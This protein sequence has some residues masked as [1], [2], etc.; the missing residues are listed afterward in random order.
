MEELLSPTFIWPRHEEMRTI[1]AAREAFLAGK[2][3]GLERLR[4]AIRESWQ[5][6]YRLRVDP[7]LQT[8]PLIL[9]ADELER[10]QE[11]TELISVAAPV[12]ATISTALESERFLLGVSDRQGQLLHLNGHA[13]L[14]QQ[15]RTINAVPGGT[16]A[17]DQ[18]GT[19]IANI[20]LSHGQ[21]DY[22][23]WNEHYCHTFHQWAS[24]GAP[25][26][27]PLT[28]EVIGVAMIG[29]EEPNRFF[30]K[31]MLERLVQRLEQLLH[32]EELR[33]RVALLDA[34][35]RLVLRYPQ[36]IV[37]A[38]DSRGH[39]CGASSLAAQLVHTPH[40]LLDTSLL[41]VPGLYVQ[42]LRPLSQMNNDESYELLVTAAER[43]LIF[44][45]TAIPVPGQRH[46]VGTIIILPYARPPRHSRALT[47]ASS[48]RAR[49]TFAD[50]I[51]KAPAF[52]ECLDLAHQAAQHDFP[53]LLLGESGSG[54]ELLA[55]AIH[56][57]SSRRLGP[58]ITVN[59]GV[60][61]DELLATELFGYIEGAFTD[62]AKG[63]RKG[64]LELAHDGT[65]F[66][67]EVDAMS[68]KMQVSLLRVL[69]ERTVTRVGAERPVAVNIRVI[70]ASNEDLKMATSQKRF[71]LDLYHRLCVVLIRIPSLR[72]RT[73]D[74]PILS[75]HL[76]AQLGFSGLRLSNDA[77]ALLR[78]YHW[79][80]NIRELRNVLLRSAQ[81]ATGTLVTLQDI[82]QEITV[83]ATTPSTVPHGSLHVSEQ[84]LILRVLADTHGNMQ[85]A[86]ARLGIH[87]STLYRK[88][89][90][91]G[92]SPTIG[93]LALAL[94][95]RDR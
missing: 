36:D 50:L 83:A 57:A 44:R 70:A 10:E 75:R 2:A 32:H 38:L 73:N 63:G 52:Q 87:Q 41:R 12:F 49:Y 61:N 1:A 94:N 21:A 60:A 39:I 13:A 42:G 11:G 66:L 3:T 5:R 43:D 82:P 71:R 35:H 78:R 76:L 62:A 28:H 55:Q 24:L 18:V 46:P 15:A 48:W 58:F 23:L 65:L 85:Q 74:L 69:E 7:N 20:V 64:K 33:R 14:L 4:P 72:E 37:L 79:P 6:C 17:E 53:V 40:A 88:L 19:T 22:V 59:C 67:D 27:H 77:L 45:A 34:Y 31:E 95:R 56:S 84:E 9:P 86:A 93:E 90:R 54:K 80:G 68:P 47:P 91:Y 92:L 26:H 89:K 8:I 25:I 30:T 29:G 81:H 16:L 51:G